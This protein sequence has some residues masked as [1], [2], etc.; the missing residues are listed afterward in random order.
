MEKKSDDLSKK[1]KF[2][3]HRERGTMKLGGLDE[4]NVLL[5]RNG[6]ETNFK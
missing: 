4:G 6:T 3:V 2:D 5:S 1:I